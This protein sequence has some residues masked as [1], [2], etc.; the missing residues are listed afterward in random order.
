MD[1]F[2]SQSVDTCVGF[3]GGRAEREDWCKADV[4]QRRPCVGSTAE[5]YLDCRVRVVDPAANV[6]RPN[7]INALQ[8]LEPARKT[9]GSED[10]RY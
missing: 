5:A 10:T 3:L 2:Q 1:A 9:T 7:Q 6:P 4:Y 8:L